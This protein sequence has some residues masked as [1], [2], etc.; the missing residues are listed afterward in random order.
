L[1]TS[2][3]RLA[4]PNVVLV[5]NRTR[6]GTAYALAK[7]NLSEGLEKTVEE[8][9]SVAKLFGI[10]ELDSTGELGMCGVAKGFTDTYNAL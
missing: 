2:A 7:T 9:N 10:E 5:T 8:F 4:V 3:E 6:A 1:P